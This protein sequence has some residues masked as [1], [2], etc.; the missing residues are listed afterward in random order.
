MASQILQTHT[1]YEILA[2]GGLIPTELQ[3]TLK[4][5]QTISLTPNQ[6]SNITAVSVQTDYLS[7]QLCPSIFKHMHMGIYISNII[8]VH[9]CILCYF[10][11][12]CIM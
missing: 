5:V 1:D 4:K 12:Y 3:A 8:D 7:Y 10:M 11:Y 6:H 2:L 9:W